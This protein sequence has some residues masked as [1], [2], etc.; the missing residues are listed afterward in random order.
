MRY[1]YARVSTE[2]QNADLQRD[3]LK[4]AGCEKIIVEKVSGASAKRPKLEKLLAKLQSDDVLIVWRLD[5][6]GRNMDHLRDTI[7]WFGKNDIGFQSLNEA[8]DTTT[9]NGELIFNIFA[10]LAQFERSLLSERTKAGLEAAK[11]RGTRLGRPPALTQA[12]I[13]HARK[14]IDGGERPA[15]VARSLGVDR[16]TLYRT[17]NQT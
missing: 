16:S 9:A 8:I 2:E 13:K 11:K 3:A 5:R 17:L 10:S 6:L 4:L 12:Q 7:N 15:S 1:G 14:L